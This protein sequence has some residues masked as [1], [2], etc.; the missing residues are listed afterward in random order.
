MIYRIILTLYLLDAFDKS[1]VFDSSIND[2]IY[3][4]MKPPGELY[5]TIEN[6]NETYEIWKGSIADKRIQQLM[7]RIQIPV[8]F[9]IEGG[10]VIDLND[11]EWSLERWTVFFLYKKD[12]TLEPGNSTYVF[13]GYSTVYR[14]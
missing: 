8:P 7:K 6:R 5:K 12:P 4:D 2:P 10:T 1:S 3:K 11:P 13:V 9:F 14:Y